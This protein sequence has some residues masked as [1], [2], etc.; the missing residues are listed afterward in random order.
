MDVHHI[1]PAIFDVSDKKLMENFAKKVKKEWGNAHIIINNAGIAGEGTPAY[2]MSHENYR[3]VMDINFFGVLNGCQCFL[4]QLVDNNEGAVVNI[5]SIFGLIGTPNSSA[6]CASKFAVRGYTESLAVE[7]HESPI[8]IHCV[9]PGGIKTNIANDG[10]ENVDKFAEKYLTT[11]PEDL[12]KR[13]IKG[14]QKK[15]VKIVFGRDSFKTWIGSNF[16]PQKMLNNVI[17][18]EFNK[19]LDMEAYKAFIKG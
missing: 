6:Y 3:K 5:S 8:T 10:S 19:I 9:H 15:D 17:W 12:A 2:S 13:I 16:L 11:P 4:P 1:L 14:I 18:K 7:F